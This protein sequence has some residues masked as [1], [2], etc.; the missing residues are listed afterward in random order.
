MRRSHATWR[1]AVHLSSQSHGGQ[2]CA[3]GDAAALC[4][5]AQQRDCLAAR[6][7]G[8]GKL[9]GKQPRP[10][11]FAEHSRLAGPRRTPASARQSY[12]TLRQ[13][14]LTSL[15]A[16]A[17]GELATLLPRACLVLRAPELRPRSHPQ[18]LPR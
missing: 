7:P 6:R 17:S 18:H 13:A 1:A 8:Q 11:G 15:I 10:S 4:H 12:V 9:R 14:D 16:L 2:L 5:H 3:P